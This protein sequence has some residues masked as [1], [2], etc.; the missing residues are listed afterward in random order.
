MNTPLHMLSCYQRHGDADAFC[1]LVRNLA[2]MVFATAKRVTGSAALAEDMA[3]ETFS[4]LPAAAMARWNRFPHGASG[5][6]PEGVQCHISQS[7]VS[8]QLD[9]GIRELRLRLRNVIS[10]AGLA[11]F[12]SANI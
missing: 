1:A 12:L 11:T 8:R 2:G 10:G 9:A 7:T 4:N 6:L 5:S 3:Q